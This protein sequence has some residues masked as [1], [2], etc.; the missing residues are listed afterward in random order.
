M[1]KAI[2]KQ[3]SS[4][5]VLTNP[6]KFSDV[7]Q[8]IASQFTVDSGLTNDVIISLAM[9]STAAFGNIKSLELP[10]LG[11][12]QVGSQSTVR[13]DWDGVKELQVALQDDDLESFYASHGG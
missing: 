10:N 6:A 11:T 12:G 2:A 7:V 4:V 3:L 5:G 8:T 13:V 9:G 1:I